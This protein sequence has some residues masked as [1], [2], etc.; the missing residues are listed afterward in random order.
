MKKI[1]LT[2]ALCLLLI[3][4]LPAQYQVL[5]TSNSNLESNRIGH[6]A[7]TGNDHFW[8][9]Y[10][11]LPGISNIY[12]T[13][14]L[15]TTSNSGIPSDTIRSLDMDTAGN[16]I[17]CTNAGIALTD[18][19]TWTVWDTS[20]SPLPS[21]EVRKVWVNPNNNAWWIATDKGIA[22]KLGNNWAV[23]DTGNSG[24]HSNDII[25]IYYTNRIW[26]ASPGGVGIYDGTTWTYLDSGNSAIPPFPITGIAASNWQDLLVG[27]DGGGAVAFDYNFQATVLDTSTTAMESNH[28]ID[29]GYYPSYIA[30]EKGLWSEYG[31]APFNYTTSNSTVPSDTITAI[32]LYGPWVSGGSWNAGLGYFGTNSGGIFS[33][34]IISDIETPMESGTSLQIGPNPADGTLRFQ[35]E[36]PAR[37]YRVTDLSGK[38]LI[39]S[40]TANSTVQ[41]DLSQVDVSRLSPGIYLLQVETENGLVSGKFSVVR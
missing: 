3:A 32:W 27:T 12:T 40:T 9:S 38:I 19:N 11:D 10:L 36:H 30:T 15:Y 35:T 29:V 22:S 33:L 17:V 18:G 28:V 13:N 5:N 6:I 2:T 1:L 16:L 37:A 7:W 23:L 34:E 20:N 4:L 8:V 21:N 26:A 41:G 14:G 31:P 24:I 25:D 39:Q